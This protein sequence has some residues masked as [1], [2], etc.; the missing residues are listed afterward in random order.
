MFAIG[1]FA[2]LAGVSVKT[3]RYWDEQ[4][5]LKP[6][7]TDAATGYRKYGAAQLSRLNRILV[8]KEL[9]FA[10]SQIEKLLEDGVSAAE[11]QGMLRLRRAEQEDRLR[12]E[13]LRLRAIEQRIS[14]ISREGEGLDVVLKETAPGYVVRVKDRLESYEEIARLYPLVYGQLGMRAAAGIPIAVWHCGAEQKDEIVGEAGVVLEEAVAVAAPVECVALP[15]VH[16]ASL[17]HRGSFEQFA[18]VYNRFSRWIEEAG[19]EINGPCR[20]L[21]LKIGNPVRGDDESY[22]TEMQIPV[23]KRA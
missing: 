6:A 23:E 21:Y 13:N 9:G 11:M 12:E 2:R 16:C 18:G 15:V 8:L 10:L 19:L 22:V 14:D 7:R 5:L 3:L 20:E 4:G 1:E 17:V